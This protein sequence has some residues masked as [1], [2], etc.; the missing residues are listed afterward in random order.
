MK[1]VI[2]ILFVLF[3]ATSMAFGQTDSTKAKRTPEQS[4]DTYVNKLEKQLGLNAD[5]KA[6]IRD[7]ALTRAKKT[8]ELRQKEKNKGTKTD[9]K[10]E[11]Q[12]IKDEF[13][14]GLKATLTAEQLT[15][16]TEM[17]KKHA[18]KKAEKKNK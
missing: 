16:W 7:L 10:A 17:Q 1:Q 5:Q 13:E 8:E 2:A 11:R 18:D 6:K 4:A 9:L 3:A 12:K 14:A 15:K